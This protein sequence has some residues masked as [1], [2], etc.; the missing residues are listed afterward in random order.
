MSL[1]V[2]LGPFFVP[3]CPIRSL[4]IPSFRSLQSHMLILLRFRTLRKDTITIGAAPFSNTI[5]RPSFVRIA[6]ERPS[7][8]QMKTM[9]TEDEWSQKSASV[10]E[11]HTVPIHSVSPCLLIIIIPFQTLIYSVFLS[12]VTNSEIGF[13]VKLILVKIARMIKLVKWKC[14]ISKKMPI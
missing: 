12:S 8:F 6:V 5:A 10:P 2:P 9:K 3:L 13:S 11:H 4:L 14:R 7:W 1:Y